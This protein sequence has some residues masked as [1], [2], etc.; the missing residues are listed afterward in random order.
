MKFLLDQGTPRSMAALLRQV[1]FD[2]VHTGE[3]GMAEASDV[4]ILSRAAMGQRVVVTLDADFHAHLALAQACQPSVIRV[5]IE[6][7]RAHEFTALLQ[8]VISQ[9]QRDLEA[10]AVV[11]VQEHQIRIR[12]LPLA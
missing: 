12:R 6:S 4:D 1:G 10:G 8:G 9:C 2:A 7:L 11:S 3:I 5:R